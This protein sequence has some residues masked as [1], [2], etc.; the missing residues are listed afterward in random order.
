MLF[1]VMK[2]DLPA[3]V[4]PRVVEHSGLESSMGRDLKM[5]HSNRTPCWERHLMIGRCLSDMEKQVPVL[6]PLQAL[7][8]KEAGLRGA[9]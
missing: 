3:L 6:P 1:C 9:T 4:Y 7:V 5:C 2:S 8:S